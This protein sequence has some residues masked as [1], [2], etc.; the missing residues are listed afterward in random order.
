[1]KVFRV[2]AALIGVQFA[3]A[4]LYF[5]VEAGRPVPTPFSVEVLDVPAPAL[6]VTRGGVPMTQPS[7]PHLVHFWATWCA[8]CLEE[9]P[10]LLTEAEASGVPILAVTDEPWPVVERYF[11]KQVPDGVVRDPSGEV[12]GSWRVS[13]L[14]DTF[15]V[16]DGRLVGRM[17]GPRN[18]QTPEAR[19][20]LREMKRTP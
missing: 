16:R 11:K 12:A 20:F 18:W 13:G 6:S 3:L 8:P 14:P 2:V 19:D 9:L 5:A 7:Q 17:G 4:G 10:G 1:V 15:V